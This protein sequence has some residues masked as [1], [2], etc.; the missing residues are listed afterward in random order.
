MDCSRYSQAASIRADKCRI[1]NRRKPDGP[2]V[3]FSVGGAA[4][5]ENSSVLPSGNA[6][7]LGYSRC[8]TG[9]SC[10]QPFTAYDSHE[11]DTINLQ[12]LNIILNVPIF[13][14]SGAFPF[15]YGLQ[16]DSY[17]HCTG[18]FSLCGGT[19]WS[20][21]FTSLVGTT[22]GVLPG[23]FAFA[24]THTTNVPCPDGRTITDTYSKWVIKTPDGSGHALP[25]TMTIDTKGCFGTSVTGQAI[26]GSGFSHNLDR[27]RSRTRPSL[28][29]LLSTSHI[30]Q[31]D[32]GL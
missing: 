19:A 20:L 32:Q 17:V 28:R 30:N 3:Q 10:A 22:N 29:E 13:N 25:A 26:D 9:E 1:T 14:K 27:P 8:G 21:G 11:A 15:T 2:S 7:V 24:N 18:T 12:N 31:C 6:F 5:K 23:A 4:E 16:M